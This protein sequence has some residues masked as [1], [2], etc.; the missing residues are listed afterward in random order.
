MNTEMVTK[1]ALTWIKNNTIDGNGITV[2]SKQRRVYPEVTG[3]YIPTLL[4]IGEVDMAISYAKYLCKI[5]KDNGAWFDAYDNDPY[6]FDSAQILKGLVAIY[7]ILPEV[8]GNILKGCDWLLSNMDET[9]RLNPATPDCFAEDTSVYSELIHLYCL[10]PLLDAGNKFDKPNYIEAAHQIKDYYLK[11]N[12]DDILNFSLLSHFYAYV[13]EGLVDIGETDVIRKAMHNIEKYKDEKGAIP[14]LYDVKWVCST[15]LF[16]LA[17]VWYKLGEIK[18]GNQ[19]FEYTCNLQNESGGWYGSYATSFK[20]KYFTRKRKKA[21]YFPK[22]EIAW[23]NKYFFDALI[24]H[25][26]LN[27]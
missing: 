27:K 5:Q 16:Q 11:N 22:E 3:Y 26:S 7:D 9:G 15:G 18:K 8:K 13:M 1:K 25:D 4:K 12:M 23:A 10:T 17:I 14:G 2:T 21:W 20:N 24:L 6:V 19:L